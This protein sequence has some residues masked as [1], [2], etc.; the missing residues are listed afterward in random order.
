[1]SPRRNAPV[2]M[3]GIDAAEA[4][5]VEQWTADGTLP[6]LA[7]LR[8]RGGYGQLASTADWLAGTPWPS[9]YTSSWP[10]DHGFCNYLQWRPNLMAHHRPND[11]WLPLRPF[12]RELDPQ[13]VRTVAVDIPITYP[14]KPYGGVEVSGWSSHDRLWPPA[15]HPP[16]LMRSVSREFGESPMP[17]EI[18]GLQRVGELLRLRD[19]LIHSTRRAGDL[20]LTFMERYPWDLFMFVLGATHRG[21]HKLWN[22]TGVLDVP[23]PGERRA[24][25]LALRD[26]YVACDAAVGR[27]LAAAPENARVLVF[28]LHGMGPNHS[29]YDLLPR[30]LELILSSG[31]GDQS[32]SRS[33]GRGFLKRM[34]RA[35][36][37]EWRSR[38]KGMLPQTAQDHLA[39][40]WHTDQHPDWS[41]TKAFAPVGDLEGYVQIN[42][43]GREA[44]GV[45][46]PSEYESL[47]ATVKAGLLSFVDED[48]GRSIVDRIGRAEELYPAGPKADHMADLTVRWVDTP[49]HTHRAI[50]SPR[51]GRVAWPTIGKNPDGRSG[52]HRPTGWL[53]AAGPG[54]QPGAAIRDAHILDLAPT[55][56][57]LLGAQQPYPMR[58]RPVPGLLT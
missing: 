53:I 39:L 48:T 10:S 16:S 4:T 44:Q 46:D 9:F 14:P 29:R 31:G 38:V 35:I 19:Q 57:A 21:G 36:P 51:Y 42:L 15:S 30:M 24:F 1:M 32:A 55:A 2:L 40:F 52:N 23:A 17:R 56:L 7:K 58:G 50:I 49:A 25:D 8:E 3:I 11:L 45:V 20:A 34:R 28:A 18:T 13:G 43:R 27:L 22:N 6:N 12:W 41:R 47:L 33:P 54:I 26:V 5:L 37:L